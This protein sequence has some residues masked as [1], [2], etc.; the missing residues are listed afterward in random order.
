MIRIFCFALICLVSLGV[1][2]AMKMAAAPLTTADVS[3]VEPTRPIKAEPDAL[4]KADKLKVYQAEPEP[5]PTVMT[6]LSTPPKIPPKAGE[7]TKIVSRHWHD[8][9]ASKSLTAI[10]SSRESLSRIEAIVEDLEGEHGQRGAELTTLAVCTG[11]SLRQSR[12]ASIS[13][14][15]APLLRAH[16][17]AAGAEYLAT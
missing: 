5:A 17:S 12:A 2:A 9:L 15:V 11:L 8:P 6:P 10:A 3:Q 4:A 7:I 13:A 1:L 16:A 14:S